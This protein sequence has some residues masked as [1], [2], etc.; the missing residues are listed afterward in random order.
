MNME[1]YLNFL[2]IVLKDQVDQHLIQLTS[3]TVAITIDNGYS[4][5]IFWSSSNSNNITYFE[6][7]GEFDATW[8]YTTKVIQPD[9]IFFFILETTAMCSTFLIHTTTDDK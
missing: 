5:G 6:S 2:V 3:T 4:Y 7:Y 1:W 9:T 8:R